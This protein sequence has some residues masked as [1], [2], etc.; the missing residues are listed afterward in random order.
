M[1]ENQGDAVVEHVEGAAIDADQGNH[2]GLEGDDH[3]GHH[4]GEDDLGHLV[5]VADDVVG[6]H[7]GQQGHQ[8]GGGDGDDEGVLEGVEE[9]HLGK[10]LDE[11]VE[12]Q[13]LDG[14]QPG[15]GVL[16]DVPL[17]LEGVDDHHDEGE[18]VGDEDDDKA[19]HGQG[20]GQLALVAA[21]GGVVHYASTSCLLVIY[22]C[23][24]LMMAT[25]TNRIRASA[26]P[27]PNCREVKAFSYTCMAAISVVP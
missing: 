8:H 21:D 3:G 25:M 9:V 27:T 13:A 4:E 2:D 11:V 20:V 6:Q 23:T 10:G 5:V 16:D 15:E 19:G 1:H 18:H 12:G 17:L 22:T 26:W 7:G 24:P 14:E